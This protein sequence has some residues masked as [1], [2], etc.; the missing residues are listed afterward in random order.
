MSDETFKIFLATLSLTGGI[1]GACLK[2]FWDRQGEKKKPKTELRAKAYED[3]IL[4][5]ISDPKH[6]DKTSFME[7][8][9]KLMV[10]GETKVLTALSDYYKVKN[11]NLQNLHPVIIAMRKSLLTGNKSRAQQALTELLEYEENN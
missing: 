11:P 6:K 1:I 9:A 2:G 8:R 7:V 5:V 10:Y 3:F 4:Q